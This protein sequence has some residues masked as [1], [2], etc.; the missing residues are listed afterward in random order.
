VDLCVVAAATQSWAPAHREDLM[1]RRRSGRRLLVDGGVFR[2]RVAV[3]SVVQAEKLLDTI[4][5]HTD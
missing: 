4:F 1:L 3:P 2:C 5:F